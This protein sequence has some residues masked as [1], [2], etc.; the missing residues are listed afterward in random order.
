MPDHPGL[1]PTLASPSLRDFAP[2][3]R[4]LPSRVNPL[5]R[6]GVEQGMIGS[7]EQWKFLEHPVRRAYAMQSALVGA[8]EK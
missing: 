7:S 4:L 1:V 8:Q 2:R 6:K 3:V 5:D